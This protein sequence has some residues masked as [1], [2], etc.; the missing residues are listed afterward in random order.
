MTD[1]P[2]PVDVEQWARTLPPSS[3]AEDR[4]R[5]LEK[6]SPEMRKLVEAWERR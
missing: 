1:K 4:Q 5:L 2:R 6:Q 3:R